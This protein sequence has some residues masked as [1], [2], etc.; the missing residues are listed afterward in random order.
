MFII[1]RDLRRNY[2][3]GFTLIELMVTVIFIA[4]LTRIGMLF[5]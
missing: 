4:I 1:K 2:R 5:L 3:Y